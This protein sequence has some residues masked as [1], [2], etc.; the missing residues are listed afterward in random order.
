MANTQPTYDLLTGNSNSNPNSHTIQPLQQT[1]RQSQTTKA[2]Q[3]GSSS[4]K[5]VA[6]GSIDAGKED[7]RAQIKTL[8]YEIESFK[9]EREYT[10]LRHEKELRDTQTKA[11]TDF[12]RAQ[13][14]YRSFKTRLKG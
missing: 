14:G 5:V 10:N 7:L 3:E 13:V 9:Q 4:C 11:D 1:F 2:G 12:K 6:K 8:L